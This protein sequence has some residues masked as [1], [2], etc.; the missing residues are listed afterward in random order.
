MKLFVVIFTVLIPTIYCLSDQEEWQQFKTQHGK[1]YRSLLEEKRRFDIFK[2]NLRVIDEH[3]QRFN[4]GEETF[5]MRIN[6]FGDLSQEEFHQMLS[7]QKDQIPSRGDDFALL[8]DNEDLPKEVDWKARGAVTT[9]KDQGHCGSCWA[10]SAVGAIEAQIFLKNGTLE[11]LSAQ[12]LV[13]CARGKYVN[14]G[15][16]GG[17]MD[18]A[19][20]YVKDHGVLTDKKYPYTSDTGIVGKCKKQGGVKISGYKDIPEWDEQ[21]LAKAVAVKGPVSVGVDALHMR[22]YS[23]GVITKKSGCKSRRENLNHGVLVV[24]YSEDY[25]LVKNSWGKT[26]GEKGYFRLKRN[27]GNTCGVA[28]IASYP[29]L[30]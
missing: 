12:N 2:S 19:F 10:F 8:D 24:A 20:D 9:V 30:D 25:W 28:T 5:E 11:S 21:A 14:E 22:F 16:K 18:Y 17:L 13:D 15:C 26:W 7:L 4:N 3:N 29:T 1:T 6:Q 27:D 23:K